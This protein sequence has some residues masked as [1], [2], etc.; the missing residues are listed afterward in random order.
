MKT[1]LM[2][3]HRYLQLPI[4]ENEPDI[5]GNTKRDAPIAGGAKGVDIGPCTAINIQR[6]RRMV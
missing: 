4:T 6:A 2:G 3:G 1:A 5:S